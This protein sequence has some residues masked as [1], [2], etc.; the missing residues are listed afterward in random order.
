MQSKNKLLIFYFFGSMLAA[1]IL[2]FLGAGLADQFKKLVLL[3]NDRSVTKT[4]KDWLQFFVLS[5]P[6]GTIWIAAWLW[7]KGCE[8]RFLE[9]WFSKTK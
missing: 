3:M 2:F 8:K 1:G 7:F 6:V 9:T 5:L 4:T